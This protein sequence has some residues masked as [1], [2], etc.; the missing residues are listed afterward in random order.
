MRN[1]TAFSSGLPPRR[2]S[3]WQ[4]GMEMESG[5]K[6]YFLVVYVLVSPGGAVFLI[7]GIDC[8]CV[9]IYININMYIYV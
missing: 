1:S 7:L 6:V 5:S 4:R 3:S 2:S 9:Y 8:V